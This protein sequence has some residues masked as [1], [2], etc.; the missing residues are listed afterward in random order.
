M[1][2]LEHAFSS[3]KSIENIAKFHHHLPGESVSLLFIDLEIDQSFYIDVLLSFV[4]KDLGT[5]EVIT[6]YIRNSETY[7]ELH[8]GKNWQSAKCSS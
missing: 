4:S 5:V 2:S 8:L 7:L 3:V 6:L 1:S